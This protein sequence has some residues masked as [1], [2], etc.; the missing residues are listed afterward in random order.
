MVHAIQPQWI[1]SSPRR[2]HWRTARVRALP[3]FVVLGGMKCGTTA[4]FR[5]LAQHPQ[6][7]ASLVKEVHFFD[8]NFRHGLRWYRQFFPMIPWLYA[9]RLLTRKPMLT[10][11]GSPYYLFHPHAPRRLHATVPQ[12]KLI[13][14][15]RD[16]VDRAFSHYRHIVRTRGETM[17]FDQVL[18]KEHA[19]FAD[20]LERMRRDETYDSPT[21][22][23][24]SLVARGIYVEQLKAYHELFP[25]DQLLVLNSEEYFA[26]PGA[27]VQRV[28]AFLGVDASSPNGVA[29]PA[30]A[31]HAGVPAE[32]AERLRAY[33]APYNQQLYNYLGIDF[34]WDR[35]ARDRAAGHR[36]A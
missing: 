6:I 9:K 28:L 12:A 16:P 1:A 35:A 2:W 34:G 15:V 11:E 10:G 8:L 7:V 14:I 3:H 18:A 25:R 23:F 13:A 33:F 27:T 36:A 30:P 19:S 24:Y 31:R 26:N 20:E 17:T 21:H 22:R 4:L 32:A 5:T 29:R